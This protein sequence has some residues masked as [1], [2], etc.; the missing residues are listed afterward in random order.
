MLGLIKH[1]MLEQLI[2]LRIESFVRSGCVDFAELKPLLAEIGNEPPAFLI[3][4]HPLDLFIKFVFTR[5]TFSFGGQ[6]KFVVGNAFPKE[7]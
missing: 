1:R 5:Q 3:V 6:R 7:E 2:K 4:E